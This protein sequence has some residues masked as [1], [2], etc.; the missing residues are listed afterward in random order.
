VGP[1]VAALV[2]ECLP[3]CHGDVLAPD[4]T[5]RW[6]F[7]LV[8]AN[9]AILAEVGVRIPTWPARRWVRAG[10][11]RSSATATCGLAARAAGEAH[12]LTAGST[13]LAAA[14]QWRP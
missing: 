10:V 3:R 6:L 1:E 12:R 4:G 13:P 9:R 11:G 8:A 14:R 2:V 7:D 5:G